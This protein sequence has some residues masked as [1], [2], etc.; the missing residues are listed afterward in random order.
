MGTQCEIVKEGNTWCVDCGVDGQ[1]GY[2]SRRH[3]QYAMEIRL[4]GGP[5]L[6]PEVVEREMPDNW[7]P[8]GVSL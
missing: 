5:L 7:T 3:A 2:K 6:S 4:W 1:D 8:M